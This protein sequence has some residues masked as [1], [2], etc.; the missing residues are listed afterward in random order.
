ME[1]TQNNNIRP[2]FPHNIN[3]SILSN[4]NE[5]VDNFYSFK[6]REDYIPLCCIIN[7]KQDWS[8]LFLETRNGFTLKHYVESFKH[9]NITEGLLGKDDFY[10]WI[11]K[12]ENIHL[13]V[14]FNDR[15]YNFY[16]SN[17]DMFKKDLLEMYDEFINKEI[18]F[19]IYFRSYILFKSGPK[20]IKNI[21]LPRYITNQCKKLHPLKNK[22]YITHQFF[23]GEIDLDM[24]SNIHTLNGS[25]TSSLKPLFS[26]MVIPEYA[27]YVKACMLN[28]IEI[29]PACLELWID[30]ELD[31]P[32]SPHPFRS[33]F[34]KEIRQY[35]ISR[36]ITIRVFDSL[37]EEIINYPKKKVFKSIKESK[38]YLSNV[39]KEAL[40][41][42][43]KKHNIV[44][45][46]EID[47]SVA[48]ILTSEKASDVTEESFNIFNISALPDNLP[49]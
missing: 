8:S 10:N 5:H 46:I 14:L 12:P 19:K 39:I 33:L 3:Q 30:K 44:D 11:T 43:R 23:C 20:L 38:E 18:D 35:A 41:E 15:I 22:D 27:P 21:F 9:K 7:F 1:E 32:K 26:M 2:F 47:Q 40:A 31:N 25:H 28:N 34:N 24:W 45:P 16:N 6:K 48:S 4:N 37:K 42:E 49:F 36:N 29:N 13:L 17:K